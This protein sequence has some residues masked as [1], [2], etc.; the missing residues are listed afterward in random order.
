MQQRADF[1]IQAALL[2]RTRG[3]DLGMT[4]RLSI[5]EFGRREGLSLIAL[6]GGSGTGQQ[7]ERI[8]T[9]G[10]PNRRWI[11]PDLRGHG[12]SPTNPPWTLLQLAN[13]VMRG[14]DVLGVETFDVMGH[15][16]GGRVAAE[17]ARISPERVR[18]LILLDPPVM[19]SSEWVAHI[20]RTSERPREFSSLSEIVDM[21]A[22]DLSTEARA[23][24]EREM[25]AA[26]ET[27]ANGRYRLRA[28]PGMIDA[29]RRDI[30]GTLPYSFGKF[31]GPVLLLMAERQYGV[32]AQ[33]CEEMRLALGDR[34]MSLT[35]Q[36]S[37]HNLHWEG[38][39]S[40]VAAIKQFLGDLDHA[41]AGIA[42]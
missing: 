24:A 32:T 42:G 13:D 17:V 29:V 30:I 3:R 8:A 31:V 6:H 36:G 26:V 14:V 20:E 28:D 19:T 21:N 12:S 33:G 34:L 23:Y 2:Q 16:L 35:I 22:N 25:W 41:D 39:D 18:S 9:R 37:G 1:G 15:S 10:L 27:S 40:T 5:A 7:W 4:E 11:C 38:F